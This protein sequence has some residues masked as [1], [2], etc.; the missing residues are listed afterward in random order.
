MAG[1][2]TS[3]NIT[4]T[5]FSPPPASQQVAQQTFAFVASGLQQN[6][7]YAELDGNFKGLYNAVFTVVNANALETNVTAAIIDTVKNVI[8]STNLVAGSPKRV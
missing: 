3:C 1:V 8:Y 4:V 7:D 5:G 2:I 6:M